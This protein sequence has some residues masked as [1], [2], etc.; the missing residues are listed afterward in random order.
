M[1]TPEVPVKT[2]DF[3]DFRD[4]G[5]LGVAPKTAFLQQASLTILRPTSLQFTALS[6]TSL[7]FFSSFF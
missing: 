3:K 6:T 2:A 5:F 1:I 4:S 7:A